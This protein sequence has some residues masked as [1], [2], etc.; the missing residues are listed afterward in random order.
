[1]TILIQL[2]YGSALPY[3]TDLWLVKAALLA[4]YY[5]LI[6]SSQRVTYISLQII[7]VFTVATYILVMCLNA[8][9]CTPIYLNW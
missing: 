9:Y 1:M 3:Y 5:E 4:F 2:I 7:T 6:P 8:F